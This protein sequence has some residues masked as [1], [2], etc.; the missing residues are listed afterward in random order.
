MSPNNHF[1]SNKVK[2]R[3]FLVQMEVKHLFPEYKTMKASQV[4][5][6]GFFKDAKLKYGLK[7]D[8]NHTGGHVGSGSDLHFDNLD[9]L[10]N[11]VG[12][13]FWVLLW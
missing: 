9:E 7:K 13:H 1:H 10:R 2:L 6:M 4:L 5:F 3:S 8:V 11:I 12:C